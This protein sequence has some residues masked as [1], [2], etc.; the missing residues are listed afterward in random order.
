MALMGLDDE[1]VNWLPWTEDHS[2]LTGR[3]CKRPCGHNYFMVK[4]NVPDGYFALIPGSDGSSLYLFPSLK[5]FFGGEQEGAFCAQK[6]I[7]A[8]KRSVSNRTHSSSATDICS[9]Q[10]PVG[11]EPLLNLQYVPYPGYSG[12]WGCSMFRVCPFSRVGEGNK[13]VGGKANGEAWKTSL[14]DI[15]DD[16]LFGAVSFTVNLCL[17]ISH[18]IFFSL[19]Y[20]I[21][22][23]QK[24]VTEYM[25]CSTPISSLYH[26]QIILGA[27]AYSLPFRLNKYVLR[28]TSHMVFCT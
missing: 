25:P 14:P 11:G 8:W 26:G 20:I 9:K 23:L 21:A 3:N 27:G 28:K 17:S 15:P 24:A 4:E 2:V 7:C 5:T 18:S 19:L 6:N 10:D 22:K 12:P 1:I 13:E 16:D